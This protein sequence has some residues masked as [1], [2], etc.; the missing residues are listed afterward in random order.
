MTD[1]RLPITLA[2][3]ALAVAIAVGVMSC[4][5]TAV[6]P[7]PTRELSGT[8]TAG[9]FGWASSDHLPTTG[10]APEPDAGDPV[11]A[12]IPLPSDVTF[13]R[14]S[15]ELADPATVDTLLGPIVAAALS[16]DG[17]RLMIDAH[18]SADGSDAANLELSLHRGEAIRA[19]I[20]AAR[21]PIERIQV[22]AHGEADLPVPEEPESAANRV[23]TVS[24]VPTAPGR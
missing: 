20:V 18:A 16:D 5:P 10:T 1:R 7:T 21:V 8:G 22:V 2:L 11:T 23:V 6:I 13:E 9:A 4:R 15:A 19:R 17:L 12:P 14:G 24:P 3:L